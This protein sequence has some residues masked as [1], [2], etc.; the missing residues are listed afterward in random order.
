[1]TDVFIPASMVEGRKAPQRPA[2]VGQRLSD[3][4]D[5][6]AEMAF[7]MP[8]V[9]LILAF[10][11]LPLVMSLIIA[12]SR[13]KLQ[14]GGFKIRYVGFQNF[15]KILF[16]ADQYHF[17]GTFGGMSVLGY[18]TSIVS[19]IALLWWLWR[20]AR[21]GAS[22]L[23][24]A[25]RSVTALVTC[26]CTV[27][28]VATLLSGYLMGTLGV[29]LIYVIVGCAVQFVVATALHFE[30]PFDRGG[31]GMTMQD[32]ITQTATAG[33]TI[34]GLRKNYGKVQVVTG[35][36]LE[37]QPGEFLV[38]LGPS[39]C[40]KSTAPRII[41]G[42]EEADAGRITLGGQDITNALP[43]ESDSAAGPPAFLMDEPLS[44]VDAKLRGYMRA[45]LKRMQSDLGITTIY[46]THDQ[47]EAMTLA[48][49]VAILSDGVV[50]QIGT[51]RDIYS[52]LANVFVAGFLGS[53]PM[54]LLPGAV[55]AGTFC[56]GPIR[57]GLASG[58]RDCDA[59]LGFRPEDARICAPGAGR[60]DAKVYASEL[61]GDH[62]LITVNLDGAYRGEDAQRVRG[63]L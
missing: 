54:N 52:N 53:P 39:G 33:L 6:R 35:L 44:T 32:Q 1:M 37:I 57:I 4:L 51:P 55:K 30:G 34:K 14:A 5:R 28:L 58:V 10:S 2:S 8:S 43:Q 18:V 11:I 45:E 62:T 60:F 38:L 47:V 42:L 21:S 49:R 22:V 12:V 61:I 9:V 36:D 40:G 7:L 31:G 25:G 16:G 23:G 63:R 13:L 27:M 20:A 3:C 50:Q 48:H 46:V 15:E 26:G 24:L 59:K 17:L 56:H 41:A 29:T 19:T